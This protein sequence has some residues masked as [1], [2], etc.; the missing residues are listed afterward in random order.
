MWLRILCNGV[1]K[2]L[3]LTLCITSLT[4]NS[5]AQCTGS[6]QSA[7][8]TTSFTTGGNAQQNL[9]FTMYNPPAD[10]MLVSAVLNS[11]VTMS[12]TVEMQNN[13]GSDISNL[14]LTLSNE[15]IWQI[16]G[17]DIQDNSGNDISDSSVTKKNAFMGPIN[18]GQTVTYGPATPFNNA[19]IFYDSISASEG[20]LS[21][22]QGNGNVGIT[23]TNYPGYTLVGGNATVTPDLTITNNITLTYYYCYVGVLAADILSFTAVRDGNQ[24]D[25]AWIAAN[26]TPDRVYTVQMSLG[27][28]A[29][30]SDLVT[31]PALGTRTQA[32]YS[33]TYTIKPTDKGQLYFRL[34]MADAGGAVTYSSMRIINLNTGI[35][36]ADFSIY[37]NPPTDFIQVS[38]P[39]NTASWQVDIINAEGNLVQR[40]FF[41]NTALAQ[42]NFNRRLAAGAYFVRASNPQNGESR[43]GSFV[44]GK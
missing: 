23:Y 10:Y 20:A 16:G 40:N 8:Q 1:L 30:F 39:D 24:V 19:M 29:D 35:T 21:N 31:V 38:L 33:N 11:A 15:D 12:G 42:V 6:L 37:P 3:I 22:F 4:R 14:K 32:A 41:S 18:N 28:G 2:S 34:K 7:I 27:N 5:S 9:S 43:T 17:N 26:E 25:L 44:I 13:T 36:T